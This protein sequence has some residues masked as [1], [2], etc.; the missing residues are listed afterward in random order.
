MQRGDIVGGDKVGGD[1]TVG[2]DSVTGNKTTTAAPSAPK[3]KTASAIVI[4]LGIIVA[5]ASGVVFYL[6]GHNGT[7]ST[8]LA[9]PL[10]VASV[11]ASLAISNM[12][13]SHLRG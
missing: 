2:G 4:T 9:I 5:T 11:A 10:G 12:I 6:L 13:A 3:K 7:I 8:G 1:K